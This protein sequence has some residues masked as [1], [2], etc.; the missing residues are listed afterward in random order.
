MP[1]ATGFKFK[2][3]AQTHFD[4]AKQAVKD[5]KIYRNDIGLCW[6]SGLPIMMTRV[7][8]VSMIQLP[9]S[10]FMISELMNS[11]RVVYMD[12]RKHTDPD[13]AVRSFNGESIGHWEGNA[14]VIDTTNFVADHH[15][16]NDQAGIP[17]SDDFHFIERI[18]MSADGMTLTSENTLID[19]KG[20][21]GNGRRRS[22]LGES[23]IGILPKLSVYRISTIICR[24][25]TRKTMCVRNPQPERGDII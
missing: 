2:P 10:I 18:T 14:L 8:P 19:P 20:W 5:G 4:A 12:G 23:M 25:C 22:A 16:V 9:T 1:P 3:A 11:L 13:V 7:W 17:A 21:R 24:A 6:P 15:W